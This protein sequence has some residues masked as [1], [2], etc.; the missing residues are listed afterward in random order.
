[1]TTLRLLHAF[2]L[3]SNLMHEANVQEGCTD[4]PAHLPVST[5]T[6]SYNYARTMSPCPFPIFQACD[7]IL[8]N[9]TTA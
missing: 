9:I 2:L 8:N 5:P 4:L 1:M 7:I 6:I 3:D